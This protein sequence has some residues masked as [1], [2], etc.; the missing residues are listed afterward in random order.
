V[1]KSST[2][3]DMNPNFATTAFGGT[4]P[5]AAD[6]TGSFERWLERFAIVAVIPAYNVH[7]EIADVL[8][9]LPPYL[10]YAIVVDDA[11]TD[12]TWEVISQCAACDLR[13]IP[14]Q[15]TINQ[16]VGGAMRTGYRKA[17]T[18]DAQVVVKLDGDGQMD[19]A[20]L[21]AVVLPLIRGKADYTKGNRFRDFK[22]LRQMPPLRR[23]GNMVLSFLVKAATGYW[24]C[25][26]PTNGF[27]A[28]RGD[29]LA[30]LSLDSVHRS[31]FFEISMLNHLNLIDAVVLD[32]PM[33]A[34]YGDETS[35]LSIRRVMREFPGRLAMCFGRRIVL[36]HFL[37]DFTMESVYLLCGAPLLIGGIL[38]GGINWI[39][40]LRLGVGAPTGT[41]VISALLIVLGFQL[42]LAAVG[43]DLQGVPHT[44][45][46]KEPLEPQMP[47]GNREVGTGTVAVSS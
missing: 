21:P 27:L 41:V 43:L 26:D 12:R 9:G 20:Y 38:F 31:Y 1:G 40:Y 22:A 7:Q 36:K 15:H 37:Y 32:I 4:R 19:A 33:P 28:I 13:I 16:G 46:S 29:V 8:R 14:I 35:N 5:V 23:A 34:K 39:R 25:F 42:L 47:V 17:S 24:N 44:P 11:S 18:L 2:R 3:S 6:D 45:L 10:R 30:Q